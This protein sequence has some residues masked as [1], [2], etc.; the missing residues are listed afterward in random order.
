MTQIKKSKAIAAVD[1]PLRQN[2]SNYPEP[3]FSQMAGRSK[4]QLGDVFGLQNFG[5]NLTDLAPGAE[6]ALLHKHSKQDEFVYIVE[7]HPTLVTCS[8]AQDLEPGM[9]VGFPASGDAHQL[10]N[11]TQNLVRILEIGDRTAGD[12]GHYPND[13]LKAELKEGAW[14]FLHKDGRA[15]D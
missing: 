1:V 4:R 15:Y 3:F 10:V 12:E 13:D 7:G 6:S 11:R 8:G 9:C 5:V 2:S 14:V